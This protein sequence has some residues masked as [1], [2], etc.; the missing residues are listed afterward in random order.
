M[1]R[2]ERERWLREHGFELLR[3][4]GSHAIWIHRET[5]VRTVLSYGAK[6][7]S[8]PRGWRNEVA[9]MRREGIA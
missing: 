4:G 2:R 9:R 3:N 8:D 1:N 6:G 5:G 7:Q